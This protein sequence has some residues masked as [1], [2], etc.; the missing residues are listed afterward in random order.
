MN[1][2]CDI[3]NSEII[4]F[5][6]TSNIE[7]K[8]QI[9]NSLLTT[10]KI[11]G[12]RDLL[13]EPNS[14]IE[15]TKLVKFLNESELEYKVLGAGSNVLLTDNSM[16]IPVIKLNKHFKSFEKT[17]N[18]TYK[19]G[20]STPVM[21]LARKVSDL[22]L[23]GLEFS[24]GI[25][26]TIGGA[27]FMNA[28]AHNSEFSNLIKNVYSITDEGKIVEH[29]INELNF[30]YR[31]SGLAENQIIYSVEIELI[32]GDKTKIQNEMRTCLEYRKKTQPL[33]LPSL[34]SI[35][36]NYKNDNNTIAAGALLEEVKLKGYQHGNI[37]FSDLHANWL[38]N[39]NKNANALECI[40]LLELAKKKVLEIKKIKLKEEIRIW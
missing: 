32:E 8:C 11:T 6:K 3:A 24:S 25:P 26:A 12:Y 31:Y 28:G 13:I 40:E 36:T 4:K 16:H 27:T 2:L 9:N 15:L 33:Q 34:G 20:A 23:S 10:L 19:I 18:S 38:V 21:S 14:L 37:M 1:N 5:L 30:S 17:S 7:Y 39:P 35:F 29:S 22:S